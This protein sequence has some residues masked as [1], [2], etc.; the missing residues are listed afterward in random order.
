MA[1]DRISA[2]SGSAGILDGTLLLGRTNVG[3]QDQGISWYLLFST[4]M[5]Y[6]ALLAALCF[7]LELPDETIFS[8]FRNE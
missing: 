4:I 8:Y 1:L 7:D 2:V 6:S 5:P 3:D